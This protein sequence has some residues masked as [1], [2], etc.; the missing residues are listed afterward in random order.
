VQGA[1]LAA[2][3]GG[4]TF[5][6]DLTTQ[7]PGDPPDDTA[8]LAGLSDDRPKAQPSTLPYLDYLTRFTALEQLLRSNGQWW[9]PHPWLA[10]FVGDAAV[11]SVVG[12]ELADLPPADLGP[13]GQVVLSRSSGSR[14]GA[15]C[16]VP[17]GAGTS[18]RPL[19]SSA[20]PSTSTTRVMCSP[21]DTR[22]S[23]GRSRRW[24]T[25]RWR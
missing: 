15:R 7:R 4:W 18:G 14:S 19:I 17:T 25:R 16:P 20:T 24:R 5:R 10:T 23:S 1:V 2:P 3:T 8:L 6:L 21:P 12:G 9:F 11:E 22:C 13:L